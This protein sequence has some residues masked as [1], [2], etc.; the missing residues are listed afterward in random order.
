[1][2]LVLADVGADALLAIILNDTRPGGGND[3]TLKLYTNNVTP[4]VT[5]VAGTFTEADG[6]GYT[7]KTLTCSAWT[8]TASDDPP[9][10]S[11]AQQ[12]WTFDGE[13][14]ATATIYGYY[15]VDADGTLLWAEKFTASFTPA[16]SGDQV[17][18]TPRLQMSS[19]TPE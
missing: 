16:T 11:Y 18:V 15:V 12:T 10:G 5:A 9:Q 4:G 14:S 7:A 13:L 8:I 1:M 3:F 6:G 2:A 17:K 19:G